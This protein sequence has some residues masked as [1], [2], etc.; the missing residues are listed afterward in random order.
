M[1]ASVLKTQWPAALESKII[2]LEKRLREMGSA[3][4]A[5]SAGTDS[6]FLTA[7]AQE[8]LGDRSLAVTAVSPSVPQKEQDEAVRLAIE[9]GIRHRLASTNE[10]ELAQYAC[11]E[12]DRCYH[13]KHRLFSILR[14]IANE[15]QIAF[16]LDGSNADDQHDYRPGAR[17]GQEQGVKSP[18]QEVGFT[19]EEIRQASRVLGLPTAD[20]PAS[21]CLASR[22]PYGTTITA[23]SLRAVELAEEALHNLGF[24]HVR[25]RATGD[26]ARIELAPSDVAKAASESVRSQIVER[27]QKAGFKF[28]TLDLQGYRRGSWN[29]RL[30]SSEPA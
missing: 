23:K 7:M 27:L 29:S 13:C 9:I 11:N 20:K 12:P 26:T 17:A 2:A 10:L 21:A 19:K 18:L 28:I 14:R 22:I 1:T 16:V 8:V 4:V 3:L 6:T 25:V 30:S 5:F 24:H 15:E